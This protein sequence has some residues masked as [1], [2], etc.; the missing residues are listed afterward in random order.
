M[1]S[2]YILKVFLHFFILLHTRLS[3]IPLMHFRPI[4]QKCRGFFSDSNFLFKYLTFSHFFPD[5]KSPLISGWLSLSPKN[6]VFSLS[7][8]QGGRGKKALSVTKSNF[9]FLTEHSRSR[10]L[11]WMIY[12]YLFEIWSRFR[13]IQNSWK[14]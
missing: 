7:T 3:S 5:I 2:K 10:F 4:H 1:K 8:K 14:S 12:H 13:L 9:V 6:E 11:S